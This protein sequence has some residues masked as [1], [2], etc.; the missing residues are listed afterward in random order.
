MGGIDEEECV[1]Q[2]YEG[3]G[4]ECGGVGGVVCGCVVAVE[5]RVGGP[6]GGEGHG[7]VSPFYTEI[8]FCLG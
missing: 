5:W 3:Y 2:Y 1:D 8:A 6:V 4:P 7:R